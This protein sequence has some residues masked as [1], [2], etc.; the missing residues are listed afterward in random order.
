LDLS[1]TPSR[2]RARF[3]RFDGGGEAYPEF[4]HNVPPG[5]RIPLLRQGGGGEL[6]G[7]VVPVFCHWGALVKIQGRWKRLINAKLDRID[8]SRLWRPAFA[9][10]RRG[11]VV[12]NGYYEWQQ[13]RDGPKQPYYVCRRDGRPLT[14][15]ALYGHSPVKPRGEPEDTCV[16]VTREPGGGLEAIHHRMPL[17]IPDSLLESWLDPAHPVDP[18]TLAALDPAAEWRWWAVSTRANNP[19]HQGADVTEPVDI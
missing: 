9:R 15:A 5:V 8:S 1:D 16:I 6:A 14:L 4:G 2:W 17:E 3:P 18:E 12:A 10:G 19:A 13:R 11:I 7:G